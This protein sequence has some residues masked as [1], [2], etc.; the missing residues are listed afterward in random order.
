MKNPGDRDVAAET[1]GQHRSKGTTD[2]AQGDAVGTV[3]QGWGI[4]RV[5]DEDYRCVWRPCLALE[6][7]EGGETG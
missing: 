1:V 2:R 3:K 4:T 6:E 7:E 5:S